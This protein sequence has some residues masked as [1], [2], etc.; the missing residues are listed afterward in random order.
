LAASQRPEVVPALHKLLLDPQRPVRLRI[1]LALT[2]RLDEKAID[3][4]ID[5]LAEVSPEERRLAEKTLEQLAGELSPSPA[6]AGNDEL[7]RKLRRDVWAAWWK[8]VDGPAL[9][10]AF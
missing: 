2:Q 3:A 1:A 5:L 7:S 6:L 8:S 9:L 10:A 4:L